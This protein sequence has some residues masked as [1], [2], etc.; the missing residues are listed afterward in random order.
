L[1]EI[2]SG[3]LEIYRPDGEKFLFYV[4]LERRREKEKEGKELAQQRAE[5]LAAKLRKMGINPDEV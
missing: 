3:E 2:A 4:E 1:F 5:K